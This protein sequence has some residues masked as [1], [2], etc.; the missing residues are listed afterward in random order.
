MK[1][2]K[3][4][5]LLNKYVDD[6]RDCDNNFWLGYE[7]EKSKQYAAALSYYLRCAE[8]TI[9]RDLQYECLLKTWL[10]IHK[11]GNRE[12]YEHK[13][14]LTAITQH[15]KRPEAYFLLSIY[16]EGKQEWKDSYYYSSVGLELCDFT[17]PSLRTYVNY[18]GNF[19][20]LFQKALSSWYVG[21][22]E[23]SK[24]LWIQLSKRTDLYGNY[25]TLTE[26]NLE[27]FNIDI[28]TNKNS[29]IDI[30]LQGKYSDYVLETAKHYLELDFVNNVII[31]CWNDDKIPVINDSRIVFIQNNYPTV[32]GTGNRNL[33][34]VSSYGGLKYVTTDFVIKM[35]NDQRY[36]LVSMVN[37]YKF[38]H[39]NK[40]RVVTFEGDVNRP[41]NRILVAGMFEGFPFHPRD[42]VF[43]GHIDDL[44]DLFDVPLEQL[45]IEDRVRMKREDY[46]KYYDCYVR[47]ESYIGTHY[48]SKF[49]EKI[50]RWLLKP[51][52]YLYD[53]A[54]NISEVLELTQNLGKSIFKSFPK[55]GIDLKWDKYE[56]DTYPYDSQYNRFNERWHENGY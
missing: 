52:Q 33:Q 31:S 41:K 54:P 17:L 20:L 45:G 14:L 6:P 8:L 34:I 47:T 12:W 21:Q 11:L 30:V 48:A 56:W 4:Q 40:E 38:F 18:P 29:E 26:K 35:R 15:P 51:D 55:E 2:L 22:R 1:E 7:Y 42:H 53:N 19:G 10:M 50:K 13:Q 9:D 28:S 27:D 24:Q 3:I 5:A 36:D 23:L 25:K 39:E 46:W 49:D 37:M 44:L 32:N 16:H 43:W